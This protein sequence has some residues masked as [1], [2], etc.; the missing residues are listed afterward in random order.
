MDKKSTCA[1]AYSTSV[2]KMNKKQVIIHRSM[3][4]MYETLGRPLLT[5]ASCVEIVR[6]V[7]MPE[8]ATDSRLKETE[9]K[10]T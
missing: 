2:P 4:L 9:E 6:K 8:R 10:F 3:A 5:E 1:I 7:A